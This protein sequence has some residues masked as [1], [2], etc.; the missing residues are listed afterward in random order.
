LSSGYAADAFEIVELQLAVSVCESFSLLLT[1]ISQKAAWR[2]AGWLNSIALHELGT[3]V[4]PARDLPGLSS[5]VDS[6]H[7]QAQSLSG[8]QE[9]LRDS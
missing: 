8:P 5:V 3:E 6:T 2:V 4:V 9:V 7:S 1:D